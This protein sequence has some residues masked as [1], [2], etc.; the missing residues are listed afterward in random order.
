MW[1]LRARLIVAPPARGHWEVTFSVFLNSGGSWRFFE[2]KIY[3]KSIGRLSNNTYVL[4]PTFSDILFT[5]WYNFSLYFLRFCRFN[6]CYLWFLKVFLLFYF[7]MHTSRSPAYKR[8]WIHTFTG[9]LLVHFQ[10]TVM[11]L[12]GRHLTIPS[13]KANQEPVK[14]DY[15]HVYMQVTVK[16]A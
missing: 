7:S 12:S 9:S 5:G 6:R 8:G 15:T 3:I 1:P 13:F 11:G 14:Y 10:Q 4:E 2:Q 16:Y